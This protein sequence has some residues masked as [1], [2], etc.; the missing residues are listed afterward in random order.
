MKIYLKLK[1]I[2]LNSH[3]LKF[4]IPSKLK[5]YLKNRIE[6]NLFEKNPENE[7]EQT[8]IIR[9]IFIQ[10]KKKIENLHKLSMLLNK[11]LNKLWLDE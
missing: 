9:N 6:L 11:D 4:F 8:K 10:D 7:N 2:Y 1:E 5:S 3:S